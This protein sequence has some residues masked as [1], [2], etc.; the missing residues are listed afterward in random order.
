MELK[1]MADPSPEEL[2]RIRGQ[3]LPILLDESQLPAA[4]GIPADQFLP[5]PELEQRR[6]R[7]VPR[8]IS[9]RDLPA[10][11]GISVAE[12][13]APDEQERRRGQ[14]KSKGSGQRPAAPKKEKKKP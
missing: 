7:D 14:L 12:F 1:C 4:M 8:A 6:K 2:E 9:I 11:Y 13:V 10:A 3:V 5:A